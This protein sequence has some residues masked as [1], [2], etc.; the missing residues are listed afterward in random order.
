MAVALN[1]QVT[2]L[3]DSRVRV[4]VQVPPDEVEQRVQRTARQ[5]GRDLKLPGFRRG[6]VPAPMVIQRVGREAVLEEAVRDTLSSWYSDAIEDAG[7]VPVGDPKVDLDALPEQG[8][9]LSFSI[10]IGVLPKARLGEYLGVDAPRREPVVAPEQLDAE[11]EAVRERLA[12]L[13]TVQRPAA[14]G[15]FV[16][17]D[18]VGRL[19]GEDGE[20][21]DPFAGGESRDQLVELGSG[22]LIPGFEEALVGASAGDVREVPLTFPPDYGA[23]QLAGRQ[24]SFEV[25]VKE[26]KTKELPPLNDDL[27]LDSGFDDLEQLK[28]EISQGLLAAD[29]ASAEAEFR[30]AALDTVV[31]GAQV[32][33]TPELIDARAS[34]MWERMLHSL[35]HRGITRESY[36]RLSGN[37]EEEVLAE[38][39]PEAELALR[40]EAV[41]T[42]VVAAEQISPSDEDVLEALAPTAEREGVEAG[43]LLERLRSSGRLEELR[44]ELAARQAIDLIAE[45][46]TPIE[47]GRARAREQLWTP[48]K[49]AGASEQAAEADKPPARLWTPDR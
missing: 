21:G 2:E 26:V 14:A 5:L 28:G 45:R 10:E 49:A 3:G 7:I 30:Q 46:A 43:E 20:P 27:A 41:I 18:Y 34:E 25:T 8:Q 11:L 40:R 37:R 44:E 35:S 17:I 32:D 39:R 15:D 48:D 1:T 31:G 47:P 38:L 16:V 22:R 13:E 24:A 29:E 6:K 33:L 23:E 36:L 9:A 42:A 12:R 4:E 19:A